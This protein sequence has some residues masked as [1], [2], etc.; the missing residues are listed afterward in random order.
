ML[1]KSLAHRPTLAALAALLVSL[2]A[3]SAPASVVPTS[4]FGLEIE[5][6]RALGSGYSALVVAGELGLA[7][8]S[9]TENDYLAAFDLATGAEKWRYTVGPLYKGHD[10]SDDGPIATPV[11]A[12][13]TVY[14]LDPHGRM[15]AVRIADGKELWARTLELDKEAVPPRY[16]YSTSPLAAQNALIVLTGRPGGG[17]VTAYDSN[18]G[19]MLWSKGDDTVSYQS[20]ILAKVGGREQ[21]VASTNHHLMGLEPTS[22]EILWQHR[23]TAEQGEGIARPVPMGED[24]FLLQLEEGAVAFQVTGTGSTFKVEE[25]WRAN[26]FGNTF[27]EPVFHEG[28]L[29]GFTGNFL[30]CVDATTGTQKWKSRPPGGRSLTLVDGHLAIVSAQGE[31]VIAAASPAGFEEKA[32]VKAFER[33][34]YTAPTVAGG[35]FLVRDLKEVASIRATT[36]T[37]AKVAGP[38]GPDL[39][40]VGGELGALLRKV[41]ATPQ[42]ESKALLDGYF[43][44]KAVLP[45][46]EADGTTHFLYR[47]DAPDAAVSGNLLGFDEEVALARVG[48]SDLFVHTLKLDPAACYDYRLRINFGE[49]LPDPNN[50]LKVGNRQGLES[51]ELRMPGWRHAAHLAEP[52]GKPRGKIDSHTFKSTLGSNERK[53]QVY[54]PA[55]YDGGSTRYS[56]LVLTNGDQPLTYGLMANTLDNVIGV[57]V[58]PVVVAFVPRIGPE[59]SAEGAPGFGRM[60]AEELVPFLESNYR[61]E[62]RREAR[63]VGG[64]ARGSYNAAVTAFQ[65]SGVFGGLAAQSFFW[66]GGAED[67]LVKVIAEAKSAPE[68]IFLEVLGMDLNIPQAQ[69]DSRLDSAKLEELLSAKGSQLTSSEGAGPAGW[70]AWR[71]NTD[72]MLAALF[73]L[74]K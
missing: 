36:T 55:G 4:S 28:H 31:L 1:P 46:V 29:Y 65:A 26:A 70:C 49:A 60:L 35:R 12:A 45:L 39:S 59:N 53:I 42:V 69:I 16:G 30:T 3:L 19:K 50:P 6:K 48:S 11:V 68:R 52:Q 54:V 9:D 41:A 43:A 5:W 7:S 34:S 58:A 40:K 17:A 74:K 8:F 61:L 47:G 10:G 64:V 51:S 44:G 67:P 32:R 14:G 66:A 21:V 27:A 24:R 37:V 23:H 18:T 22:G 56:L 15:F 62:A 38:A 63:A 20:P 33:S 25:K 13:G 2:T 71:A 57:S 72:K 73:P